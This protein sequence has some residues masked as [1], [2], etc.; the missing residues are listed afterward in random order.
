MCYTLFVC[1]GGV[2]VLHSKGWW[3]HANQEVQRTNPVALVPGASPDCCSSLSALLD[4]CKLRHLFWEGREGWRTLAVLSAAW[5]SPRG[6][7]S[8]R[9]VCIIFN[10]CGLCCPFSQPGLQAQCSCYS[11]SFKECHCVKHYKTECVAIFVSITW[12]IY[13]LFSWIIY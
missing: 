3:P 5:I 11:C 1:C 7:H 4:A 2:S 12:T 13:I 8:R 6:W 10:F 9:M